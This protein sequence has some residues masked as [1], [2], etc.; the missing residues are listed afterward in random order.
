MEKSQLLDEVRLIVEDAWPTTRLPVLLSN[1]PK[2]LES[3]FSGVGY[4]Q[5][6]GG[7]S[8]KSFLLENSEVAGVRVVQD[9]AHS[10]RVGLIPLGED[11][12][13]PPL[14][15]ASSGIAAADAQAFARVLNAMTTEEKRTVMLPASL[16]S[17]LLSSR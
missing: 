16:V 4:K 17:R 10:A 11:Y 5:A 15:S 3:K 6:L 9:P 12:E 1:M 8:L 13:F 7:M 2:K 14:R